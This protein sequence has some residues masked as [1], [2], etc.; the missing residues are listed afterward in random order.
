MHT[1]SSDTDRTD[2]FREVWEHRRN[3]WSRA[4]H[5]RLQTFRS[6]RTVCR[7]LKERRRQNQATFSSRHA[8]NLDFCI[9]DGRPC[10]CHKL[11]HRPSHTM[12][13]CRL[14]PFTLKLIYVVFHYTGIMARPCSFQMPADPSCVLALLA[15]L[16]VAIS[17]ASIA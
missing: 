5:C 14:A 15:S 6:G 9:I 11:R 8:G 10:L 2:A 4:I 3:F 17:R 12:S 7:T 16:S 1:Y 13:L